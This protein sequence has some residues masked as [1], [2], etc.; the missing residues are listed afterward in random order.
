MLRNKNKITMLQRKDTTNISE[1][2]SFFTSSEKV[3][4]TV[5]WIMRSLKLNG[6]GFGF[7]ESDR[8]IYGSGTVLTFLLLFPL[9]QLSNVRA[10]S[11]SVLAKLFG[12]GKD[13][14][15]RLKNNEKISWRALHYRITLQLIR[16]ATSR[17]SEEPIRIKV[18][19]SR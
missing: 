14:F 9:F 3:C 5:L 11:Q 4:E 18:P 19:D 15:Y 10:F 6:K 12:G 2:N 17:S 13:V 7:H 16:L 1:L 8:S